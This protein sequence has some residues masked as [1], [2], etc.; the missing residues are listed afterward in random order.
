[1][2]PDEERG[3]SCLGRLQVTARSTLGAFAL[4][5]GGLLLD[6]GW[7]RIYGGAGTGLPGAL[8]G[9]EAVNGGPRDDSAWR[10]EN[11]I[12]VAHD[13]LGGAFALNGHDPAAVGRPGQPGEMVYFAP[14]SLE[15]EAL[16]AGHTAWVHWALSG[17]LAQFY[18]ALRWPGW[19][20]ETQALATSQ[21][22]SVFPFLWSRE[23][24]D[25]MAA[26]SRRAVPMTEVLTL[27]RD[28]CH[29]LHGRDPGF[30]GLA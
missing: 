14:D 19:R 2:T 29:Q 1:M 4:H 23:A 8:P 12:V 13:V 6:Y 25:D 22:V 11:G 26:T 9:L 15:W 28:F 10:P 17:G 18:S 24:R 5:C 3:R 7:L 27:N 16:D 30:L 20:A 21:G